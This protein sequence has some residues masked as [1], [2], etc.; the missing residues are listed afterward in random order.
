ME[1]S[2]QNLHRRHAREAFP[3]PEALA[4]AAAEA[5]ASAFPNPFAEAEASPVQTSVSVVY[6][7]ASKTFDGPVGGYTTLGVA[8]TTSDAATTPT[9]TP[10]AQ[11]SDKDTSIVADTKTHAK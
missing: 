3:N 6:V 5:L 10:D 11:S 7:T 8:D 2:H 9:A 1:H 4:S